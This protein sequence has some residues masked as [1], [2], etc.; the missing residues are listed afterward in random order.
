V[1]YPYLLILS[2]VMGA[3]G[4]PEL[5]LQAAIECKNSAGQHWQREDEAYLSQLAL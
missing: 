3:N 5:S 2:K 4:Q 1:A